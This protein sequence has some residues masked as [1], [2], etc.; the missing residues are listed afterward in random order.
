MIDPYRIPWMT[1]EQMDGA[2]VTLGIVSF[3]AAMLAVC[4]LAGDLS[5]FL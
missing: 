5:R 4:S 1:H 2:L 3:V